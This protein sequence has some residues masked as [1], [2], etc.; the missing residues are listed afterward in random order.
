MED[1]QTDR[2]THRW[3]ERRRMDMRRN[4]LSRDG[5]SR[6][7]D[8]DGLSNLSSYVPKRGGIYS[9]FCPSDIPSLLFPSDAVQHSS[10]SS[11][12]SPSPYSFF[13]SWRPPGRHPARKEIRQMVK[14]TLIIFLKRQ[15]V[16]NQNYFVG[17]FRKR[18]DFLF[19]P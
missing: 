15:I 16:S 5:D 7:R 13:S 12:L 10:S 9:L 11:S 4:S 18:L 19:F 8:D 17:D 2:Q 1:G 14:C 3:K 6:T